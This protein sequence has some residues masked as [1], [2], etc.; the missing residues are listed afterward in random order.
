MKRIVLVT[1]AAGGLLG[2]CASSS[3]KVAATYIS[4]I[5][6]SSLTCPQIREESARVAN[7]ASIASGV[8]DDQRKTDQVVTVVGAV[9][10]WPSL[11]FLQGDN[12]KTAELARLKGEMEAL[13]QASIQRNCGIEYR[14]QP[15]S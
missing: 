6:Y 3:D 4:P 14:R 13:E 15:A 7:R 1:A 8:Q 9:V 5:Q 12:Q 2:A 10:F 11:F